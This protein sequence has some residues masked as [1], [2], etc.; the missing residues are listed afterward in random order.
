MPKGCYSRDGVDVSA[1]W[2][3]EQDEWLRLQCLTAKSYGA[4]AIAFNKAFPNDRKSRSAIMGRSSRRGYADNKPTHRQHYSGR[5]KRKANP[6]PSAHKIKAKAKPAPVETPAPVVFKDG[7]HVQLRQEGQLSRTYRYGRKSATQVEEAKRGFLP[8]VIENAPLTSVL[9]S[10][11]PDNGCKW[12][13]CDEPFM[14]CGSPIKLGSYCERHGNV[15]FREMPTLRRN[16]GYAKRGMLEGPKKHT[17]DADAQ[18]LADQLLDD[19]IK[20]PGLDEV[21]AGLIKDLL[22][23]E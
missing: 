23:N 19:A 15:A 14:V 20:S 2:T 12:P 11:C 5:H 6:Q 8:S 4:I 13:T 7:E 3:D 17:T 16:K 22:D 1:T 9:L 21:E 10:D 18:W